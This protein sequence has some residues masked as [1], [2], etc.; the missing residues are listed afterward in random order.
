MSE[1]LQ[2]IRLES[3]YDQNPSFIVRLRNKYDWNPSFCD[4][5]TFF[6]DVFYQYY[7]Q[8][9][10]IPLLIQLSF[11]RTVYDVKISIVCSN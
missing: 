2:I 3:K 1:C 5:M 10:L 8:Y 11:E 6:R 7:D 4:V 9:T